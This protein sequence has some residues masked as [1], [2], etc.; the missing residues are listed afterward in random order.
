MKYLDEFFSLKCSPD[1]LAAS[2]PIRRGTK[3]ITEAMAILT[4]MRSTVLKYPME[5]T[6][7]D[8]CS[9]NAIVALLARFVLPLKK[10]YAT[11]IKQA[12]RNYSWIDAFEYLTVKDWDILIKFIKTELQNKPVIITACHPCKTL[13]N[14]VIEFY[15]K[16]ENAYLFMMPCCIGKIS[17]NIPSGIKQDIGKY[18]AWCLDLALQ[19]GG[20][21]KQDNHC[22]S[23]CNIIISAKK[24]EAGESE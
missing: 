9:G 12:P 7:I 24:T 11:D 18:K 16:F 1:I 22:I 5:Y 10:V 17:S 20:N 19:A 23:P 8:L 14:K 6:L 4:A 2:A 21:F 3:E 13:A 15:K